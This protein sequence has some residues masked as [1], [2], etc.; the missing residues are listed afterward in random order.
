MSIEFTRITSTEPAVL[1]KTYELVDGA[2]KK[3]VSA[4]MTQGVARKRSIAQFSAF[5]SELEALQTC[6]ALAYG[7]TSQEIGQIITKQVFEGLPDAQKPL[8]VTR[9]EKHFHWPEGAAIM[10]IDI[11]PPSTG[12]ALSKEGALKLFADVCP[13]LRQVPKIWCPSSSSHIC[14]SATGEDLTG[15][16]G[17]RIY[18]P[19]ARGSEIP[20]ISNAIWTR[21]WA[22]GHGH[23]AISKSGSLLKRAPFDKL[24]HQPSR[25]DFAAGAATGPGLGQKRETPEYLA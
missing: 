19:V 16:R 6:D 12:S 24:V 10:M 5:V 23:V 21:M 17:Q 7:I 3:T 13:M 2:L 20:E 8:F 1:S 22:A 14:N 11:D 25:L 9:S 4:Q 15:L 18:M